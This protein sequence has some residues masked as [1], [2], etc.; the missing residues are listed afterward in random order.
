MIKRNID[1]S[2][3]NKSEIIQSYNNLFDSFNSSHSDSFNDSRAMIDILFFSI[4]IIAEKITTTNNKDKSI[5]NE[6]FESILKLQIEKF[7][8]ID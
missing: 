6:K 3:S 7:I 8:I 1:S 2:K 5:F 4:M